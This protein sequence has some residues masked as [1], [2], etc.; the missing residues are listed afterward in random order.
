MV[1]LCQG[2]TGLFGILAPP[3]KSE[4]ESEGRSNRNI[5]VSTLFLLVSNLSYICELLP[6]VNCEL[7]V[8]SQVSD[9]KPLGSWSVKQGQTLTSPAVFNTKTKE[10]V[11]VSD[12]KV[13]LDNSPG[14]VSCGRRRCIDQTKCTSPLGSLSL[15]SSE[16]GRKRTCCW[17]RPSE[18]L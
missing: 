2:V 11:A 13:E 7:L 15:R 9:Q 8:L 5:P 3:L 16:F 18:P 6:K 17:T 12:L 4:I 10:Y 1:L 14:L